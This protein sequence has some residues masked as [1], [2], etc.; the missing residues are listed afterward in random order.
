VT[1]LD[2]FRPRPDAMLFEISWEVCNQV[3][4]IY[5]VIRSK[6][7][8]MVRR[9][10]DAYVVVGPYLPAMADVEFEP[11]DAGDWVTQLCADLALQSL[12]VREGRWLISGH[13]RALLVDTSVAEAWRARTR[14]RTQELLGIDPVSH[15][16]LMDDV[17]RFAETVRRL[18]Q[19]AAAHPA[20]R[21]GSEA[22]RPGRLIAHFHEWVGGL[23]LP[24]LRA[25]RTRLATVFTTHATS[26]GRYV[27]SSDTDLYERL[28][29]LDA[30]AEAKHYGIEAQ[31]AIERACARAAHVFTT[32]SPLTAEECGQLLGR[33][34]DL[35]T[36]NGLNINRFDLGHDFQT[37]HAQYKEQ[38]HRF[39][40]G[41]F[42]P[43]YSFDL[44]RTIYAFTAGRF[45]PRNKGFDLCL[46]TLARL[47]SE[48]KSQ[49]LDITVIFFIVTARGTRSLDPHTL[50]AH[51]I[52]DELRDVSHR[53]GRDVGERLFRS[54]AAGKI[55]K[56]D[57]LI[58]EY[59][60]LRHR[61]IAHGLRTSRL[62]PISTHVID[63]S[64]HDPI[65][66][67]ARH[68]GLCNAESDPVK[69][70]Y[71]PEFINPVSPLWAMDYEQFVRGCHLGI[72]PSSYEPWGY[73][74][75]ECVAMGVPAVTSDLA[76]FGRYV[77]TVFP[78]HNRWGVT[79][80][81]RRDKSFHDAAEILTEHV[82]E[83]CRLDR[84]GRIALRNEVEAHSRA[85][86]W[87]Q[88]G[89]A[90]HRA[91]DRALELLGD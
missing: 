7:E 72:F 20:A 3:G 53:I 34:P 90:Y 50:R 76:G 44:D 47:N 18:L 22:G 26:V 67:H 71:H 87:T 16:P 17:V 39:V 38:I 78:D 63:D 65:L 48:L 59:W 27:T 1:P 36:P 54:S 57:D 49:D 74:P 33:E 31:H 15:D 83:F 82:I 45:E 68:L 62:P 23:A 85:F 69:L 86:D 73:T 66:T 19:A 28:P 8:A 40:M 51:G 5:Q 77:E 35:L 46:E 25:E 80:L 11:V 41:H 56:L 61:R 84:R 79:V 24:L 4:G 55:P 13:P 60:R 21:A 42:F 9:W 75:L 64:E 81:R 12:P 88:L 91:H 2:D 89:S 29:T 52:L 6:A 14:E 10:G 30:D 58:E 32:L 43:S 37:H 70:V